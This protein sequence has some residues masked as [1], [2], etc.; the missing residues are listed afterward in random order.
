MSKVKKISVIVIFS[1]ILTFIT[2]KFCYFIAEKY[3]F[4]KFFYQ[5]SISY[6][7]SPQNRKKDTVIDFGN[8]NKDLLTL[9]K[10]NNLNVLGTTNDDK[11]YNIA[12]IG[13]SYVWGQGLKNNQR[14]AKL[15]EDKLNK[16]RPVIVYSFGG[17]GDNIFDDYSKYKLIQE[18]YGKI[19]LYIFALLFND[20]LLNDDH[21]YNTDKTF[22]SLSQNCKGNRIYDPPYIS[23]DIQYNSFMD[24]S[25][26]TNSA[27][28]CA[29]KNLLPLLP[30]NNSIY[31][32][33]GSSQGPFFTNKK[34]TEL[35]SGDLN[36]I[37]VPYNSKISSSI[38][39]KELHPPYSINQIYS[40]L[41]F[42]E[43][44]TNPEWNF[45]N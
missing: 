16:I 9:N 19:D 33:L 11:T 37:N 24:L 14:F 7:Y 44:T 3:F 27:N 18:K 13:D 22:D 20:L 31:I 45:I 41:L 15:L 43:I 29:Y 42:N 39:S 35:L 6:G 25:L 2:Y 21:R 23:H 4:D 40:N 38:S 34:F 26:D 1:L 30:Q 28:Y 10:S 32:N 8:R 17:S 5:K 12:I 36:I